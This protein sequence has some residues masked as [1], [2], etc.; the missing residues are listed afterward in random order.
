MSSKLQKFLWVGLF[1]GFCVLLGCGLKI[2]DEPA[3]NTTLT[4]GQNQKFSCMGQIGFTFKSYLRAQLS[5]SDVNEFVSCLSYSFKSFE[6]YMEGKDSSGYQP[7]ELRDFLERHFLK[8]KKITDDLL[9]S[10]MDLKV[11]LLGGR[12]DLLTRAELLKGIAIIEK[13]RPIVLRLRPLMP[14]LNPHIG[15]DQWAELKKQYPLEMVKS[16]LAWSADNLA[17][18]F[19]G[20]IGS[21]SMTSLET[22]VSEFR[23]FVNWES[24]FEDTRPP[25]NWIELIKVL[26]GLAIRPPEDR[27]EPQDWRPLVEIGSSWYLQYLRF[28]YQV[29]HLPLLEGEGLKEINLL[30]EDSFSLID[31]AILN[32]A[33][34]V[35]EIRELDRLFETLGSLDLLPF[36]IKAESFQALSRPLLARVFGDQQLHPDERQLRG[37]NR[38]ALAQA[39]AEFSRWYDIQSFLDRH[40]TPSMALQ[41]WSP[42]TAE[43]LSANAFLSFTQDIERITGK[44]RPLFKTDQQN[45]FLVEEKNLVRYNVTHNFHNLSIMNLI[46]AAV[47]LAIRGYSTHV[48]RLWSMDSGL[49]EDETQKIYDAIQPMGVDLKIMDPRSANSG[50]RSFLEGN[51]FTYLGDGINDFS[52]LNT[53]NH[54]MVFEETMELLAFLYSGGGFADAVYKDLSEGDHSNGIEPC[55]SNGLGVHGSPRLLR[56]CVRDQFITSFLKHAVAMP[57]LADY[58]GEQPKE[59]QLKL[60]DALMDSA[61]SPI[62]SDVDYVEKSEFSVMVMVAHYSESVMTRYNADAD[63]ILSTEE[64]WKA[65]PTFKGF[66]VKTLRGRCM[67]ADEWMTESVFRYIISKGMIPEDSGWTRFDFITGSLWWRETLDRGRVIEVFSSIIKSVVQGGSAQSLSCATR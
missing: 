16:E 54:L 4:V 23:Q 33:N 5:E 11:T 31:R 67:S 8:E 14:V 57:E 18:I 59:K 53:K 13:L 56:S 1:S 28:T 19:D 51:M 20:S 15:R 49:T 55:P 12:R 65:Y 2:G 29:V 26:K 25:E 46:R 40:F 41:S 62:N 50:K 6:N 27:I 48:N 39:Q 58:L 63:D 64:I 17:K 10:F 66:I 22:F 37:L 61:F 7:D 60:T 38:Y 35:I 36:G 52:D 45:V 3:K 24:H 32:H 47:G 34:R 44:I 21:Y 43:S 30:F 42:P 9:Y